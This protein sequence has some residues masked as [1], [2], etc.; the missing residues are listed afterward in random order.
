MK[1]FVFIFDIVD[2]M[3]RLM[4]GLSVEGSLKYDKTLHRLTFRRYNR[5]SREPGYQPPGEEKVRQM[6]FGWLGR[7]SRRFKFH[8]SIPSKFSLDRI[9]KILDRDVRDAKDAIVTEK[10][11]D[12][13]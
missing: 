3:D 4:K 6:D 9:L 5:L 1:K 12:N 13:V 11:L 8:E 7:T 2:V 10:I